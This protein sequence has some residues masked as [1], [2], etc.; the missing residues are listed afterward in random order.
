MLNVS[1]NKTFK[2][3]YWDKIAQWTL[4]RYSETNTNPSRPF[5]TILFMEFIYK[6]DS[7]FDGDIETDVYSSIGISDFH[8]I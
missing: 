1:L 5:F 6:M 2:L 7:K 4:L 8:K 3:K